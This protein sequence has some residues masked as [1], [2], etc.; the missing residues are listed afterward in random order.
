VYKRQGCGFQPLYGESGSTLAAQE[1]LAQIEITPIKDRVGQ[2]LRNELIRLFTPNGEPID[3]AYKM[4]LQ[5]SINERDVFIRESTD[6]ERR[7]VR[8]TVRYEIVDSVSKQPATMGT[9]FSESSYNRVDSEFANIRARR[10]AENRGAEDLAKQ[11]AAQV[12]AAFV[13]GRV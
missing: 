11:V 7:T 3:A 5:L 6:V 1:S 8:M 10:D 13:S 12:S 2:Q 4:T 9:A